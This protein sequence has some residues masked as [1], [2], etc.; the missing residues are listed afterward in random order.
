MP[1]NPGERA[2]FAPSIGAYLGDGG[3]SFPLVFSMRSLTT[4]TASV[5]NAR[6]MRLCTTALASRNTPSNRQQL[7]LGGVR[8]VSNAWVC[9]A[10]AA[11]VD[12]LRRSPV[13]VD[14]LDAGPVAVLAAAQVGDGGAEVGVVEHLLGGCRSNAGTGV[15]S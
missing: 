8:K 6:L 13:D 2:W 5:L 15:C 3:T 10:Q 11:V 12:E 9:A 14:V 1:S 7:N 4:W